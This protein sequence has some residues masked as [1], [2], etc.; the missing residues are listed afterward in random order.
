LGRL[1]RRL[2]NLPSAP[3]DGVRSVVECTLLKV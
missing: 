2:L 1:M 3:A